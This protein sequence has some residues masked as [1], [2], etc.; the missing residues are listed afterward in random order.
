MDAW[1]DQG[2]EPPESNYPRIED[3][4][5]VPLEKAREEFPK[6]PGRSLPMVMNELELLNFGPEFGHLGGVL[7]L[8]PPAD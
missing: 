7:T 3:G 5:L 8:Q 2:V 4:T 1:V 6:I